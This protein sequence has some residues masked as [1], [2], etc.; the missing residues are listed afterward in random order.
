MEATGFHR[1]MLVISWFAWRMLMEIVLVES[2]GSGIFTMDLLLYLSI[3]LTE[4]HGQALPPNV[5]SEAALTGLLIRRKGR[6]AQSSY[7]LSLKI[8]F[9]RVADG[10]VGSLLNSLSSALKNSLL[11]PGSKSTQGTTVFPQGCRTPLV[12]VPQ[13][14]QLS[15]H[16]T[17][18]ESLY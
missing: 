9:K 6:L 5:C 8:S 1:A 13:Q 15:G 2:A 14:T 10:T 16:S 18:T 4:Y 12:I 3:N 17:L 7:S 11:V